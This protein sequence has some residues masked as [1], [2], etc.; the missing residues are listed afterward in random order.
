[1]IRRAVLDRRKQH[2]QRPAVRGRCAEALLPGRHGQ[3]RPLWCC[4]TQA[5]A[6]DTLSMM[7]RAERVDGADGVDGV[8]GGGIW[9]R[10]RLH[11]I[12]TNHRALF[13]ILLPSR[14]RLSCR[15]AAPHAALSS[16]RVPRQCSTRL[17]HAQTRVP[18]SDSTSSSSPPHMLQQRI[19]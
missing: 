4:F 11:T 17:G 14:P 7:L 9:S 5:S 10:H 8:S 18:A 19:R 13:L 12:A 6:P 2:S 3:A 15:S 16:C 1:V